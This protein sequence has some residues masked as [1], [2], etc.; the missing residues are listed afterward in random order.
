LKTKFFILMGVSGCG[1]TAIGKL[2]AQRLGW[3]FYDADDFHPPENIAKMTAGIPLNDDDRRPWLTA[4]HDLISNCLEEGHP[5]VLACSALKENY[6]QVLLTG[7]PNVHVVYLKGDFDLI[8]SRMSARNGH[9]MK[10]GMLKS[11]F[12]T[13]EEPLNAQTVPISMSM[14]EIVAAILEKTK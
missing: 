5:G 12:K 9:Y 2:L 8:L 7:N 10:P 4:L 1:K 3:D 13:L 6:R 14:E 11:Q